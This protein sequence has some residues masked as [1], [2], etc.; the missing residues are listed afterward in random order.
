[1]KR[2]KCQE[3]EENNYKEQQLLILLNQ[4][5]TSNKKKYVKIAKI[6]T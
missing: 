2:K 3:W 4:I 5:G 1:M 6:K